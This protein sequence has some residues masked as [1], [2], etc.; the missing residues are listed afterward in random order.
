MS[1]SS[2]HILIVTPEYP[3]PPVDGHTL[4]TYNLFR[5][6]GRSVTFDLLALRDPEKGTPE[7]QLIQ[8]LGPQCRRVFCADRRSLRALAL[9]PIQKMT[10]LLFPHVFSCGGGV[11]DELI[12]MIG[13]RVDSGEYA[14]LYCCGL[15]MGA[16]AQ[17]FLGKIPSVV[18]VVDSLSLLQASYLSNVGGVGRRM[19]ETI[20][21][22]WAQRYERRHLGKVE[23][24]IFISPVDRDSARRNCPKSK[25]WIVPNGVDTEYFNARAGGQKVPH[26]LLFTGVMEYAPNHDAMMYF[27]DQILPQIRQE[28]PDVSLVIA[29]RNP[30]P[31]LQSRVEGDPHVTLTGYVDD[32]RPYFDASSV[33]VAPLRSGAGMKNKILEAWAMEIPVVAT[34]VSCSGIAIKSGKNI[35]VADAPGEIAER[36]IEL[37]KTPSLRTSLAREGRQTAEAQY[38]W[39]AQTACLEDILHRAL[40]RAE[41]VA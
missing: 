36:V 7:A 35:V 18:D 24:L 12:R 37:L 32:I 16:H 5:N 40:S 22:V 21:L 3:Y 29:G 28:L 8:Q 25:I 23:D 30:L 13:E 38:S 2:M 34:S 31:A 33:Y 11:S 17:P 15:S 10:N 26:Q 1:D 27:L 6:F 20:N 4:R 14:L 41:S 19:K 39:R 9:N